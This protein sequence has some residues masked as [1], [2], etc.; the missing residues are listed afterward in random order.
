MSFVLLLLGGVCFG[1]MVSMNGQLAAHIN[2]LEISFL[3]HA[4]GAAM[5]LFYTLFI[6]RSKISLRGAPSYV[7]FVGFLGIALVA[8][9]SISTA[10]IGAASVM[11]L[12]VTGQL[13]VS[14]LIDHFGWFHSPISKFHARRLPAFGIILAGLFLLIFA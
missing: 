13:L 4:I 7:Y 6:K 2:L 1:L 11:A 12:S 5:L 3:V 8:S 10:F 9:S 14:A